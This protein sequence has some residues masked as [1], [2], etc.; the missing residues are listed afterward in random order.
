MKERTRAFLS[1]G[2]WAGFIGYVTVV[3]L[4]AL[5]NIVAGRSPFYTAALF[6]NALVFGETEATSVA[7]APGPVL[8]FNMIHLLVF[9][10]LGFIASLCVTIGERYPASQYGLFA[11]LLMVGLHLYA[12]LLLLGLPLLGSAAWWQVGVSGVGA[13]LTMGW[14][15]LR[16]HPVLRRELRELQWG[17]NPT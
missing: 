17:E 7:I 6:G 8:A 9:L 12:G 15:L 14:Y 2:F 10:A 3:V 11:A 13:A 5:F 16:A 4:V 1:G